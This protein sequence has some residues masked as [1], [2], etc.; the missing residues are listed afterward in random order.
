MNLPGNSPMAKWLENAWLNRYLDREL[1]EA[2]QEWFETYMLDKPRLLELVD[3]DTR[4]GD[5]LSAMRTAPPAANIDN[6]TGFI[7]SQTRRRPGLAAGIGLAAGLAV[8]VLIPNLRGTD[9]LIVASPQRI[10]FD[11]LRGEATS[12]VSEVGAS[13]SK[14]LIVD[15]AISS[16]MNVMRAS[17]TTQ[18]LRT[19]LPTPVTS[20]DG[21]ITFVVP[22]DWRNRARIEL[23][24]R[25]RDETYKRSYDL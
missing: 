23:E 20:A 3:N 7:G 9:E 6:A 22:A 4:L 16:D 13:A 24:L 15:I 19:E 5:A 8:G 25:G 1:D 14:L 11:T 21:F 18:G 12:A 17:A 2:E 10:V